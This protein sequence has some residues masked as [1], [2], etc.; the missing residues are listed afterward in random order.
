MSLDKNE[1]KAVLDYIDGF[2][3]KNETMILSNGTV[4]DIFLYKLNYY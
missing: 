2:T 1:K 3:E 4:I